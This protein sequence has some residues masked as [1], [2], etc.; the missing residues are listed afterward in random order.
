VS[1]VAAVSLAGSLVGCLVIG[2]DVGGAS[3]FLACDDATRPPPRPLVVPATAAWAPGV[4]GAGAAWIDCWR[5][6]D[7]EAARDHTPHPELDD[8]FDCDVFDDRGAIQQRGAFRL[9]DVADDG[10][11]TTAREPRA[12]L[13]FRAVR[14]RR[15][16]AGPGHALVD[17]RVLACASDRCVEQRPR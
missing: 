12:L 7:I 5:R 15:I 6:A 3:V 8:R 9:L 10:S 2:L 14:D 1:R 16:D 17:E 4:D 13:R 11:W